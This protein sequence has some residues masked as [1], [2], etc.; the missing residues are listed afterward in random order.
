MQKKQKNTALHTG[1]DES[2]T[3]KIC[4]LSGDRMSHILKILY[5]AKTSRETHLQKAI[6]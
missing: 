3:K 6:H 2:K 5:N 1:L 4:T